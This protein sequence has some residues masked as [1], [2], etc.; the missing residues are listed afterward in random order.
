MEPTL[1]LT[2]PPEAS[3]RV[4]RAVEDALGRPVACVISPLLRIEDVDAVLPIGAIPVLTSE[5][6]AR[7]AGAMGCTG[8]AYCVGART[9]AM[10][11]AQGM[12]PVS[13][14]GNSQ[15]LIRLIAGQAPRADLVHIRGRH[16]TGDVV[17]TLQARGFAIHDCVAYDQRD[18]PLSAD[19]RGLLTHGKP[20]VAALFSPRSAALLTRAIGSAPATWRCVAMSDAVAREAPCPAVVVPRPEL[21]EMVAALCK[22]LSPPMPR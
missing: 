20:V 8:I 9:A 17:E 12:E 15:D 18:I 14:G 1:L 4:Q 16:T 10:A 3:H 22:E 2:R 6:G 19:A 7:R 5:Q 11:R 13:A 21:S